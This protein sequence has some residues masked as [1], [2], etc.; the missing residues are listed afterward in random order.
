MA[1][2]IHFFAGAKQLPEQD[3]PPSSHSRN[4]LSS[5]RRES[6]GV[7]GTGDPGNRIPTLHSPRGIGDAYP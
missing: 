6:H 3:T 4:A 7:L 2:N 5:A 1:V